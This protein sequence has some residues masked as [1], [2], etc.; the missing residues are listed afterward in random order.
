MK[1]SIICTK[2]HVHMHML[3]TQNIFKLKTASKINV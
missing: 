1:I 3:T 2:L